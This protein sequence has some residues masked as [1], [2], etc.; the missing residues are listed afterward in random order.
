MV[1]TPT[2]KMLPAGAPVRLMTT[3]LEQLSVA[4]AVPKS[5]EC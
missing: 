4:V 5:T 1:V 2:G 3:Q